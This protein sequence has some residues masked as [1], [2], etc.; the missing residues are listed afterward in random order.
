[1]SN[2]SIFSL[3]Q[4]YKKQVRGQW[5]NVYDVWNSS[6][7]EITT[8]WIDGV[9]ETAA[10]HGYAAL[11]QNTNTSGVDRIDFSNDT[12]TAVAKGP[13]SVARR[14]AGA[15]GNSMNGLP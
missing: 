15:A 5:S 11:G 4:V 6:G 2:S 10:S 9:R 12:A 1:M 3:D 7:G 13:L 8:R 14:I